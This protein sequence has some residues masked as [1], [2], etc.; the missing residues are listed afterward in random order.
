MNE[1]IVAVNTFGTEF[2]VCCEPFLWFVDGKS[3][4]T[5]NDFLTENYGIIH[6]YWLT[7]QHG[8][9]WVTH[10]PFCGRKLALA[11]ESLIGLYEKENCND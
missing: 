5:S 9:Y 7:T 11:G 1:S 3:H 4:L 8:N 6:R 2:R 10:C